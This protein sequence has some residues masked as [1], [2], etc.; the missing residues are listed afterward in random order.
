[1]QHQRRPRHGVDDPCCVRVPLRQNKVLVPLPLE[2]KRTLHLPALKVC[3]ERNEPAFT[4]SPFWTQRVLLANQRKH[5]HMQVDM[6][7]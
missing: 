2:E 7:H 3:K 6:A 5:K 4:E 1:M